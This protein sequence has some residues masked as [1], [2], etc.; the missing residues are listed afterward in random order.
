MWLPA[1]TPIAAKA[2]WKLIPLIKP[3]CPAGWVTVVNPVGWHQ[4]DGPF[5]PC[6][7]WHRWAV[8]T[9]NRLK[10]N[11]ILVAQASGYKS[12]S[13]RGPASFVRAKRWGIALETFFNAVSVPNARRFV[14]ADTPARAMDAPSCVAL[15]PD[16]L[17]LCSTP[18]V[19]FNQPEMNQA[20]QVGALAANAALIDPTRWLCSAVCT[21]VVRNI[22]VYRDTS[23]LT[24]TYVR[25][26]QDVLG[27][28]LKL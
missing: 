8:R 7:E 27:Q 25:Y 22:L 28:V 12:P 10:P 17:Q 9:I 5:I 23:H 24:A 3:D 15:H 21:D 4:T 6:D 20:E 19:F 26:L 11:L 18:V 13:A 16:A 2:R 14:I 1:L